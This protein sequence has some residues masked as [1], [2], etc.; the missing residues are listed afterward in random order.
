MISKKS[1]VSVV[2]ALMLSI[3]FGIIANASGISSNNNIVLGKDQNEFTINLSVNNGGQPYSGAE[4]GIKLNGVELV[5]TNF[6][7]SNY[8]Q[9]GP[10]TKDGVTYLGFFNTDNVYSEGNVCTLTLRYTGDTK[11]S[12]MLTETQVSTRVN[13]NSVTGD[14][15]NPN[16]EITVTR[17]NSNDG[18]NDGSNPGGSG[19]SGGSGGS[20]GSNGSGGSGTSSSLGGFVASGNIS[21]ESNTGNGYVSGTSSNSGNINTSSSNSSASASGS[22]TASN[23]SDSGTASSGQAG[24]STKDNSNTSSGNGNTADSNSN[25]NASQKS[26][27]ESNST[28]NNNIRAWQTAVAV[29]SVLLAAFGGIIIWQY[30][31]IM[32]LKKKDL[33]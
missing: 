27:D 7:V 11:A 18:T 24:S 20:G 33:E 4:F 17:G 26:K 22:G 16:A 25:A 9:A 21:N 32:K 2:V 29:L 1:L 14:K 30:R 3:N 13:S 23:S 8:N 28:S 15:K 12:M 5:S 31:I 6:S 10:V 19:N